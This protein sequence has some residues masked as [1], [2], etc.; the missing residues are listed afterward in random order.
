MKKTRIVNAYLTK[1]LLLVAILGLWDVAQGQNHVFE[2]TEHT[3][4]GD[5]SLRTSP[6]W[7]T[8]RGAA[9]GGQGF[10]SAVGLAQYTGAND[11]YNIDGYVK[12]YA[13][14]AN[15]SYSFPVGTGSDLRRL[16]ID[17]TIPN[18]AQV[19]VAWIVG[20]PSTTIDPTDAGVHD[21]TKHE[22]AIAEVIKEG[23]WDWEVFKESFVGAKISVSIPDLTGYTNYTAKDLRLVGWNG[24]K[25][26]NLSG[27]NE[28]TSLNEDASVTGTM[29]DGITAVTVGFKKTAKIELIKKAAYQGDPSKA[30]VG[31]EIKYTF[32]ATNTGDVTLRNVVIKDPMIR[33]VIP[34]NIQELAVGGSSAIFTGSYFITAADIQSGLVTNTAE[35]IAKDPRNRDVKDVSGTSGSNNTP[36]KVLVNTTLAVNDINNTYVNTPVSGNVLTNDKD[37]QGNRR[38]VTSNTQP[39]NGKVEINPDGS[40]TYTPS[41]DF[42]GT[43][44]FTYVVCDDG[45][46]QACD[47]AV[48]KIEV[49][50]KAAEGN[51]PPVANDDTAITEINTPVSGSLLSNDYDPDKKDTLTI[52]TTPVNVPTNGTVVINEDGTYTYTPNTDFE[53][54]DSFTYEV[55]DNGDPQQ[56]NT[57]VVTIYVVPNSGKNT[58]YANDDVF[59]GDVNTPIA[60][61]VLSNDNDLEGDKQTVNTTP[62]KAPAHGTLVLNADGTFTYTA[63]TCDDGEP[64][65]CDQAT[66]F[67]TVNAPRNTTLA[68]N[69]INNTYVNTPVS[70]NVLTNDEDAEGDAQKVTSNTQPAHGKVEINSDGSY[71]YT[72]SEDFVGTDSF[73]YTVCD[74]GTPQACDEAVVRIKVLDKDTEGNHPPVANDDTA[75]LEENTVASG[76]LL[77]NDYDQD[78]DTLTINTTPVSA[79]TNGTVVINEDGTYTYTPNADFVGE[80]SF[81]YEVCDDGDPQQCDTAIVIMEH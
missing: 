20:N 28:G 35:V 43:D 39:S 27:D 44:S 11:T 25:W 64:Q 34:E 71:T 3:A 40:Y 7:S 37:A 50:D 73:T 74:D 81:T 2:G 52:N 29:Q 13:N 10:F 14:A 80:D 56:C 22:S 63:D 55:C 36:T 49:L 47:E 48:V 67:L 6:D 19:A 9:P 45:T 21:I 12:H 60:G 76:S 58:T 69:D 24:T 75:I 26:I 78:G 16:S 31:D 32:I 30:K 59:N 23:Q 54:E 17:G 38:K 66:V 65:A 8:D 4:F 62:V 15:Q 1:V 5:V 53:G 51:H 33:T 46:P 70:G 42:V 79:P 57:A 18:E 72:P 61:N 41:E 77:S 68:V